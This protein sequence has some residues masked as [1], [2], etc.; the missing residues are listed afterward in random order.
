MKVSCSL[1]PDKCSPEVL[2]ELKHLGI[3]PIITQQVVRAVFEGNES[4][5][6]HIVR[7]FAEAGSDDITYFYDKGDKGYVPVPKKRHRKH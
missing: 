5:G 6:E 1:P 7:I 4:I 3:K 2:Q